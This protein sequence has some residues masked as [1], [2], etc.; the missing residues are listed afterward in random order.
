[1]QWCQSSRWREVIKRPTHISAS[2]HGVTPGMKC[3]TFAPDD[4]YS[5]FRTGYRLRTKAILNYSLMPVVMQYLSECSHLTS[6]GR[7]VVG[8]L[9]WY[10]KR[11]K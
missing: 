9:C 8:L 4:K 10:P 1:M 5:K 11:I 3:K 6:E 2:P 7:T